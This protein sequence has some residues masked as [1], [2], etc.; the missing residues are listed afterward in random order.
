MSIR[1]KRVS[2]VM[3]SVERS[4][5]KVGRRV[6]SKAVRTTR[7][8]AHRMH[9]A[10]VAAVASAVVAVAPVSNQRK[11]LKD[12]NSSVMLTASVHH[13]RTA[14][15]RAVHN[16]N[17]VRFAGSADRIGAERCSREEGDAAA[18]RRRACS[19]PRIA[20]R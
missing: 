18:R 20:S 16:S 6:V 15:A 19:H 11:L 3:S 4:L 9:P 1:H 17:A 12:S 10:K 8:R 2:R 13:D 7:S 5:N 14:T